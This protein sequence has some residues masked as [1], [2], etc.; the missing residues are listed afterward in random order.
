MRK[1]L[2]VTQA[3]VTALFVT[4]VGQVI[5]DVPAWAA[6]KS[7]VISGGSIV[8]AAVFVVANAVHHL[9]ESRAPA[10]QEILRDAHAVI[11]D[12]V[13]NIN[14]DVLV[15]D[16]V[17]ARGLPDLEQKIRAEV[18]RV[19]SGMLNPVVETQTAIASTPPMAYP[20]PS[21]PSP[22]QS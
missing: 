7:Q 17:N 20:P 22:N 3:S 12:E 11:R 6:Y 8:I 14:F 9:A 1:S 5:A 16:A 4:I 15:R 19:F 13:G 2:T 21:P 10:R 18:Q